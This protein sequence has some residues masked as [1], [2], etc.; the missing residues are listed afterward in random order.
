MIPSTPGF[1]SIVESREAELFFQNHG[2][3]R[4][5]VTRQVTVDST[6]VDSGNTPTTT[7]RAGL[8]MGIK[9]SDGNA[10]A[11]DPDGTDGTENPVGVLET[12]V[13]ML[14]EQGTAVDRSANLVIRANFKEVDLINLDEHAKTVL[15][16]LGSI[17]DQFPQ[18]VHLPWPTT[19]EH[20]T[21]SLTVTASDNGRM[22]IVDGATLQVDFTLPTKAKGLA[23]WFFNTDDVDM[24]VV[25]AGNDIITINDDAASSVEY[26]T[27]S[28][29][30]GSFCKVWCDYHGANLKWFFANINGHT[31]TVV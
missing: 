21:A 9:T 29:K 27:G 18:N 12:S 30:I 24:R 26:A 28:Q 8:V 11:Y 14:N 3:E 4:N 23:F 2:G 20:V 19:T 7:L 31:L 10:Y 5:V 15:S 17:F 6:A 13:N 16:Q 22:F 1:T 25:G